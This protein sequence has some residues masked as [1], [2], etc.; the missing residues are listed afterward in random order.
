MSS[1]S[2]SIAKTEYQAGQDAF[3]RG[4][5]RQSVEFLEKASALLSPT[6]QLAGEVHLWLVTA[7]EAAGLRTEAIDLCRKMTRHPDYKTRTEGKRILY[8][9]EAPQLKRPAE[10]LTQIPDLNELQNGESKLRQAAGTPTK[11]TPS[12]SRYQPI[13]PADPDQVDTQD[14]RFVWVALIAAG[15]VLVSLIGLS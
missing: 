12:Q 3:E 9:L 14:N 4:Q 11:S 15:L 8:I 13:E 1:D 2:L 6:S 7:Y 10:W 5:Y